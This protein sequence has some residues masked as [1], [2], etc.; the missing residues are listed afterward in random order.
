[1]GR[2]MGN[3]QYFKSGLYDIIMFIHIFKSYCV[4]SDK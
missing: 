4:Q 3:K 2:W 1:M